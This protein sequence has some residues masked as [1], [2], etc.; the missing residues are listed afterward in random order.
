LDQ[1]FEDD[2]K[3][4]EL[5]TMNVLPWIRKNGDKTVAQAQALLAQ[6]AHECDQTFLPESEM[7][8]M[9]EIAKRYGSSNY[10]FS[11]SLPSVIG[12]VGSMNTLVYGDRLFL[13]SVIVRLGKSLLNSDPEF[14]REMLRQLPGLITGKPIHSKEE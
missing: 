12:G 14:C 11:V 6:S 8:R 5:P 7:N 9:A 4:S 13:Q 3:L 1:I 2:P 10:V